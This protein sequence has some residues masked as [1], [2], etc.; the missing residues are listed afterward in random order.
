[1]NLIT[2]FPA[3]NLR[4]QQSWSPS[5]RLQCQCTHVG[6]VVQNLQW[7][8]RQLFCLLRFVEKEGMKPN[9]IQLQGSIEMFSRL[10]L[11]MPEATTK[12]RRLKRNNMFSKHHAITS[13]HSKTWNIDHKTLRTLPRIS[14]YQET[15]ASSG[16]SSSFERLTSCKSSI[17][18]RLSI[19]AC[20]R[21]GGKWDAKD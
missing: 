4:C 12:H 13:H 21:M 18:H 9:Y 11:R 7:T 5:C 8:G 1:M 15:L 20:F 3:T 10:F 19:K 14:N 16:I 6:H 17:A 2:P